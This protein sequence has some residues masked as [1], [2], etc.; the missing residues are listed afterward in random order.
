MALGKNSNLAE[1]LVQETLVEVWRSLA[2]FDGRT[3]RQ[4]SPQSRT[5][6]SD[7]GPASVT[8]ENTRGKLAQSLRLSQRRRV[9]AGEG[10]NR[11]G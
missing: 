7:T 3:V 5:L 8:Y 10:S 4:V 2:R 6:V 11:D 1:D 9:S